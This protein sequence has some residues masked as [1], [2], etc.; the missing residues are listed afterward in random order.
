[1]RFA[2][3]FAVLFTIGMGSAKGPVPVLGVGGDS[4][5]L[6]TVEAGKV[7]VVHFWATWCPSCIDELKHLDRAAL[8][9]TESNVEIVAVNVAESPE[10]VEV[11]WKEQELTLPVVIDPDGEFWRRVAPG[12]LPANLVWS[13]NRWE[14]EIG[15]RDFEAWSHELQQ[16][17]CDTKDPRA[18]S[19]QPRG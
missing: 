10:I 4:L 13:A 14:V 6:A 16:L 9:C 7:R 19:I 18:A 3:V 15:P 8:Q 17:G 5:E 12:G 1:M 11:F 2:V